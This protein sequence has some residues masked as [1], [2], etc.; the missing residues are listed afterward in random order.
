MHIKR[1][2][3]N[4]DETKEFEQALSNL[5]ALRRIP[6]GLAIYGYRVPVYRFALGQVNDAKPP[7]PQDSM[8]WRYFAGGKS[9]DRTVSGDVNLEQTPAVTNLTYG[10]AAYRTFTAL[11]GLSSLRP[12]DPNAYTPQY[13]QIPG[14]LVE[15][16]RL[17]PVQRGIDAARDAFVVPYHSLAGNFERLRPYSDADFFAAINDTAKRMPPQDDRERTPPQDDGGRMPPQKLR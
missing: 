3:V 7:I 5:V 14:L 1:V 13:L 2:P 15:A 17:E 8:T 4:R 9:P 16:F 6:A 10:L 12:G 11:T